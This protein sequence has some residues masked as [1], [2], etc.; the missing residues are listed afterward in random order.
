MNVIDLLIAKGAALNARMCA[1]MWTYFEYSFVI[2]LACGEDRGLRPG[3]SV[4]IFVTTR[5]ARSQEHEQWRSARRDG[6]Q[7]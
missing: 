5:Y 2:M 4:A 6:R 3:G 1:S 7:G